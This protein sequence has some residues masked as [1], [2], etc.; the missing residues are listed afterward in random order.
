MSAHGPLA[1]VKVVEF[2][3]IGPAPH[4]AM[5]LADMGADVVRIDRHAATDYPDP[6]TQRGRS[7]I[8][9]DL[10]APQGQASARA[11][12]AKADVVIEGFRPGVMERLG[13]GPDAAL[14]DNPRLIYGRMTGWGQDGPL[15][16][17]AGHDINYIAVAGALEEIGER[18]RPPI[19][20]I[21]LVG[22][23][24]GGA[25]FLAYGIALA[26]FERS[27]SGLGQVIDAAI[28]DG[29]AS[30]MSAMIG[31]RQ[32]LGAGRGVNQLGG[33]APSY[34]AYR[35]ADG[36]HI[37]IGAIE[38][39]FWHALADELGLGADERARKPQDNAALAERLQAIFLTAPRDEWARRL[40]GADM[41]VTPIL[42]IEEAADHPHLRA[43]RTYEHLDDVLHPAPAPRLS[44]TPGAIAGPAPV[45]GSGGRER[46]VQWGVEPAPPS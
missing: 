25:M 33:A 34:R 29:T 18:D 20:P 13:L 7:S 32:I 22:A 11:A 27:R 9:L 43:R 10:K 36:R 23:F 35:C 3:G 31:M 24:G 2:A 44:R 5:M 8:L 26:L 45:P 37:A 40:N 38:A 42:S 1:G 30:L 39:A 17:A 19:P 14:T 15:A 12:M 16:Q 28:V 41:C 46:L 6:V 4:C 21:N